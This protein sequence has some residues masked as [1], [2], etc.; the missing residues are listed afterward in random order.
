MSETPACDI[1]ASD[2]HSSV[3]VSAKLDGSDKLYC[4]RCFHGLLHG[5]SPGPAPALGGVQSLSKL[6]SNKG[7]GGPGCGWQP[8]ADGL[9]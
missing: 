3:L 8:G 2:S 7:L 1:C 5:M 6:I 4:M 9:P